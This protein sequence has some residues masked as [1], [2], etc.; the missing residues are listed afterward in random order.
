MEE[1]EKH[2]RNDDE[3]P[4]VE[5]HKKASKPRADDG[6]DDT[7]SSDMPDVEAH[8]KARKP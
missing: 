6:R 5:A 3:Q 1:R 7:D 4:D 2:K 8:M